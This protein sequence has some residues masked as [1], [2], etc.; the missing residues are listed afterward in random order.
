MHTDVF[1]SRSFQQDHPH[2]VN[3]IGQRVDLI[4]A[5]RPV[6]HALHG[7]KQPAHQNKYNQEEKG[8]EHGL[9][10]GIGYG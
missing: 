9:L 6:W 3:K 8:Q 1:K 4:H 7:S 2:H 5:L 10:L